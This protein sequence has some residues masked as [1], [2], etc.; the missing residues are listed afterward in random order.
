DRL[1]ADHVRAGRL[2]ELLGG[3]GRAGTNIVQVPLRGDGPPSR[4]VVA[5]L[6]GRGVLAQAAGER[7]LRLV[8][9]R[10]LSDTD[11]AR[12]ADVLRAVLLQ[13]GSRQ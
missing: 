7:L 9:H 3:L 10:D 4:D 12:A 2:A 11:I 8:T 6:A 13:D 5:E 1:A